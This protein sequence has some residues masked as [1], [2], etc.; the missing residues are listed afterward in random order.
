MGDLSERSEITEK[1]SKSNGVDRGL[2]LG[3]DEK[4]DTIGLRSVRV[5]AAFV[6]DSSRL[7]A[8]TEPVLFGVASFPGMRY[9]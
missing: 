7:R 5:V 2:R 3:D 1:A 4:D 9:T 8:D 6:G